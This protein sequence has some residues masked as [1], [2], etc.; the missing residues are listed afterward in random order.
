MTAK[1]IGRVGKPEE[2]ASLI[3][4]LMSD[5]AGWITGDTVSIDGGRNLASAR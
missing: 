1:P 3:L 2:I 5:D 4:F